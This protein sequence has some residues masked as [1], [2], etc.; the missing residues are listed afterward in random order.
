MTACGYCRK[1]LSPGEER[2]VP[3]LLAW[4]AA[5]ALAIG[6]GGLWA[7]SELARPYCARCLWKVAGFAL[8]LASV[9]SALAGVGARL[10]LTAPPLR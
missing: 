8:L 9:I 1:P 4:L 3:R 6:H 10:W 7:K 2:R 5:F